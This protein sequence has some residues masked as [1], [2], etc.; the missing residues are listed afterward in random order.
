MGSTSTSSAS[1]T[2]GGAGTSGGIEDPKGCEAMD[3]ATSDS[4]IVSR[5]FKALETDCSSAVN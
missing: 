3:C 1:A 2:G 4:L 5:R